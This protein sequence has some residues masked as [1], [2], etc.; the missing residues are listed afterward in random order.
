LRHKVVKEVKLHALFI[1]A[2]NWDEWLVSCSGYFTHLTLISKQ[3]YVYWFADLNK[4][5]T[6]P[7]TGHEGL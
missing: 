1:T 4:K 6:I 2:L 5:K 7:V 3:A